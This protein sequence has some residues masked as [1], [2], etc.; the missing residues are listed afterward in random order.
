ML[1]N[2]I[3][4]LIVMLILA[5]GV[6]AAIAQEDVAA[7]TEA[8]I[9]E[10]QILTDPGLQ[11]TV[12]IDAD[13][14]SLPTVLSILA[15][16]SGYNI[17]TGPGVNKEERIS[18]HLQDTPIEDAMNLVVRAA[19]LS[20]EIV[21]NS[22]LIATAAKLKEQV[23]L[24]SYVVALK[25][26]EA[27]VIAKLLEDFNADIQVDEPGNKLLVI[28]SPK[29]I[30]DIQRVVED[31]DR[32]PLQ[33]ML[34]A[35]VIQVDVE[36]E[37]KLGIA[38]N[39]MNN[40]ESM[41]YE[42]P[43]VPT[44]SGGGSIETFRR[45]MPIVQVEDLNDFGYFGRQ[46]PLFD[47]AID[48]LLKNNLAEV[49]ANSKVATMNNQEASIEVVDVIPFIM[50]AGG[51]GGQVQTK[52]KEVGVKLVIKPTVNQDG[53]ITATVTPEISNVFQLIGPD[54][55]VPWIVTR[56]ATTKIRVKDGESIVIAGLLGINRQYTIYKVPFLGDMPFVGGLFR[57]KNIV[58]KKT[59]LIIQITPHV[60]DE[61]DSGIV[62]NSLIKRVETY[63][64]ESEH[65]IESMLNEEEKAE[66]EELDSDYVP[67]EETEED[68]ELLKES[69]Q[70]VE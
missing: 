3:P 13:D 52:E 66:I 53:Y 55:N 41:W 67:E 33:I 10:E 49:L 64:E 50:S 14:A 58:N 40:Y 24:T 7:E 68:L 39:K 69:L 22:F 47:F 46:E 21:G 45:Q 57:H 63:I 34:E 23:G 9:D 27:S 65:E 43:Q 42:G 61:M 48:F 16:E 36:E 35:R 44:S 17:V 56:R 20:Y 37:E 6:T 15:A 18:I 5:F 12:T 4:V 70:Q 51:V 31:V 30:H 54:Q 32:P 25:Y 19:G 2:G 8:V 29:V 28:T 26:A 62:K 1:R 60:I 38:W 59:D 11:K